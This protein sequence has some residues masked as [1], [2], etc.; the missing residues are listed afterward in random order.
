MKIAKTHTLISLTGILALA[1]LLFPLISHAEDEV[2]GCAVA[3]TMPNYSQGFDINDFEINNT[4][5][6]DEGH[7]ILETGNKVLDPNSIVIPFEQE[8]SVCFIFEGAGYEKTD[9]GW[10]LA[11]QGVNGKK[12]EIYT[13]VNDNNGNG[14]LDVWEGQDRNGD[15]RVNV[16]DNEV[17]LGNGAF[18]PGTEL[19]FYLKVDN[20]GKTFYTKKE[21]NPDT[22]GSKKDNTG[23]DEFDK[24]YNLGQPG[25]EKFV[26]DGGWLTQAAIDR[27]RQFFGIVLEGERTLHLVKGRKYDHVIVGAPPNDPDEWI[28]GWDDQAGGPNS[29]TDVDHNDLVFRINRKTGGVAQLTS[30]NAIS[31]DDPDAYYTAIEIE[32]FDYMP[33]SGKTEIRYAISVDN[34]ASWTYVNSWDIV[35]ETNESKDLL[36]DVNNWRPGTPAYTYR[37]ARIDFAGQGQLGRDLV[38][39]AELISEDDECQP[40]VIDVKLNGSVAKHGQFARSSPVAQT[41]VLYTGSYETPDP[42]WGENTMR[43][44]LKATRIYDPSDP[45]QTDSVEIWNA[46]E[47][48]SRTRIS[49]RNIYYPDIR[50]T[51]VSNEHLTLKDGSKAY[52]DGSTT[53]FVAQLQHHPVFGGT[54]RI[55]GGYSTVKDIHT[56]QL[57]GGATGHFN[58][59]TGDLVINFEKPPRSGFAL[60]ANYT[61]YQA[62]PNLLA[63]TPDNVTNEM[64]G[65]TDEKITTNSG[66]K[67]IYDLNG[68]GN[69]TEADGDY[70]VNWVRG[71]KDGSRTAKNWPLGAIDHSTPAVDVPPGTPAWYFSQNTT[72]AEREV[73]ETFM[74]THE[75]RRTQV[76][77][78]SRSG[79]L[80]A[81]DGG[82]FRWGDNPKT[83]F[84]ELRGY[85]QWTGSRPDSAD[86]GT[87]REKWAFIPANLLPRLK[88]NLM[89]GTDMAYVDASPAVA[90]VFVDGQ[91]KSVLLSAQ[92]NGG[93]T[94]FCLNVTDLNNPQFMWEFADPDLYRS[95]SSPSVAK[96]GKIMHN[97]R[98]RWAA[99]FVSGKS[100][101]NLHPSIFILDVGT[102]APIKRVWLTSS[103]GADLGK[104]GIPS[105]QP[106]LVDSDNDGYVDRLYV[107][108][109]QGYLYKVNMPGDG[110]ISSCIINFAD[111]NHP[112]YASPTVYV[113]TEVNENG[114]QEHKTLIFFGTGDSP[115]KNEDINTG[116][117]TYTFFAYEDTDSVNTCTAKRPDWSYDLPAGERVWT[118]AFAAAGQLYFGTTT[119]ETEDPCD[120]YKAI[121][122]DNNTGNIYIFN[123]ENETAPTEPLATVDSGNVQTSPMVTDEHLY[124][125]SPT[126]T[127]K[128]WGTG[129]YNNAMIKLIIPPQLNTNPVGERDW[130]ELE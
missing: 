97:G 15:G 73:Y 79:M 44:H 25:G 112:I 61:Y 122:E 119:A 54:L 16:L 77:V 105:G 74:D 75:E 48:L 69:Y 49:S 76:Y 37:S 91:W 50:Y 30:Q 33:C 96:I 41:N 78:G 103:Y 130:R 123:M 118:S 43:G 101:S 64:L 12:N 6:N 52:G 98:T 127:P 26:L 17:Q 8:V 66:E 2:V 28:L 70:L 29:P 81:F 104:G 117:T 116:N 71:Y 59:F 40:K 56:D 53:E 94:V 80:H 111:A 92:G 47:Q 72:D 120:G 24:T 124:I 14:V 99:F 23:L 46:G 31:P 20:E 128:S 82:A 95:K 93:D 7:I 129:E 110:T 107:G 62:S 5:V 51:A 125:N 3:P 67:Y 4:D 84:E 86:Y 36:D 113:K 65:L 68:D 18:A 19:V 42:S 87:G 58:R 126:G 9:F 108:T 60:Y 55:T 1:L 57:T 35:K 27:M 109:D 10:M 106:A 115:Y 45:N 21:W 85:F 22:Y 100:D 114:E 32:V 38:W 88:N 11:S 83:D 39:K 63:F 90:D 121:E 89:G 34:G 13:N 102:G